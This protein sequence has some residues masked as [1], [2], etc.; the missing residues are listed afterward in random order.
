[1]SSWRHLWIHSYMKCMLVKRS[2][3]LLT[4]KRED[5]R[6]VRT[7][8]P[9]WVRVLAWS[10]AISGSYTCIF[11]AATWGT[12][13]RVVRR[14]LAPCSLPSLAH[15]CAHFKLLSLFSALAQGQ[16]TWSLGLHGPVSAVPGPLA[17]SRFA[18][19][20]PLPWILPQNS[21]K[22]ALCLCTQCASSLALCSK[23]SSVADLQL[24]NFSPNTLFLYYPEFSPGPFFPT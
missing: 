6:G 12:A 21:L 2:T 17:I 3:E 16:N 1:M 18:H 9:T 19:L 23:V 20:V 5:V 10:R 14:A 11:S 15:M 8:T 22:R 7:A 13:G 24:F 4:M